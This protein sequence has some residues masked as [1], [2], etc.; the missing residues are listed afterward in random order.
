M[1]GKR[2]SMS[3]GNILTF[4]CKV[5]EFLVRLAILG[6]LGMSGSQLKVVKLS[7][8]EAVPF[9]ELYSAWTLW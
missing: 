5:S 9:I 3:R 1:G 2:K 8:S 7:V 4:H 6:G